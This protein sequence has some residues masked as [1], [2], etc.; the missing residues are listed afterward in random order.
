V[1]GDMGGADTY[2]YLT[3]LDRL[4]TDGVADP[5]RLGVTGGSYGGFMSSWLITQ[6]DRF[7]AAAPL[8]PVTNWVSEHLTSHIGH[9]CEMFLADDMTHADGK[10]HSRSP[11]FF[12]GQVNTPALI[13]CGSID[14]NT[15]PGQAL[16]FH[17]ALRMNGKESVLLTYPNEGHGV[18]QMPATI[19]CS[20][21]LVGWFEQ[22]MPANPPSAA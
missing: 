1:F 3:G 4:V 6:D 12:A 2:D 11:V 21:R 19:D 9:F 18:R 13:V 8:A 14:R 10:Y 15:P 22:H 20:A 17:R 7:A 5:Q 16:E